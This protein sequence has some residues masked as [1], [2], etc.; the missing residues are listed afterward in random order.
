MAV[1]DEEFRRIRTIV[2]FVIGAGTFIFEVL[3]RRLENPT[4]LIIA[5]AMMGL[6]QF[7]KLDERRSNQSTQ[8]GEKDL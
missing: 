1:S 4:V 6:T 8:T 7:L 3:T 2:L 5:A